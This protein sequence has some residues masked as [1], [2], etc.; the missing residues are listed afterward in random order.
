MTT[1]P[2]IEDQIKTAAEVRTASL[3]MAQGDYSDA[4]AAI[5]RRFVETAVRPAVELNMT[6]GDIAKLAGVRRVRIH[7]LVRMVEG[8]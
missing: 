4:V 2:T 5:N 3:A 1:S 6:I 7:E 8:R